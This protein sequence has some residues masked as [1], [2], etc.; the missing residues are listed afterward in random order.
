MS[1]MMTSKV[2]SNND[3]FPRISWISEEL[4]PFKDYFLS[5]ALF[6]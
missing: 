2:V 3:G 5:Q 4:L 6:W 1:K